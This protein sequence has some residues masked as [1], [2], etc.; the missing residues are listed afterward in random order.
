MAL[1]PT[2]S[3]RIF[4]FAS[5]TSIQCAVIPKKAAFV[6]S[7]DHPSAVLEIFPGAA[8]FLRKSLL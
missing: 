3:D 7:A 6:V 8:C 5:F 4:H 2:T 1:N